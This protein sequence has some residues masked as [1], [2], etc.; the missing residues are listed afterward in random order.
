MPV[1]HE[2]VNKAKKK[3]AILELFNEK[4]AWDNQKAIVEE[5]GKRGISVAQTTVS[6]LLSEIGAEQ[7]TKHNYRW[8]L[9]KQ[10]AYT[11]NLAAL[12]KFLN[13]AGMQRP[14]FFGKVE[15]S[16]MTTEQ[17]YNG[18]VAKKYVT[19]SPRK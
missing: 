11:Q 12:E 7:D 13:E 6:R 9:G 2:S 10:N 18:L 17:G 19:R 16:A 14:R 1:K 3:A 5:L 4:S 15:V 8:V